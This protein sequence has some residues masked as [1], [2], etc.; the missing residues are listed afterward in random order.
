[1][2]EG[3]DSR[4]EGQGKGAKEDRRKHAEDGHHVKGDECKA[5]QRRRQGDRGERRGV[6]IAKSNRDQERG[7]QRKAGGKWER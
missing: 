1:M 6:N 7:D 4:G 3:K 2:G 5:A